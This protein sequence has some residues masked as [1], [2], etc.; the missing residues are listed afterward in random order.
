[1]DECLLLTIRGRP[2]NYANRISALFWI[3]KYPDQ[4]YQDSIAPENITVNIFLHSS[5]SR[6]LIKFIPISSLTML[7]CSALLH[8]APAHLMRHIIIL[9]ALKY[10]L[11]SL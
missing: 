6:S 1:M 10:G 5:L 4:E 8:P 9:T 2:T 3:M 11:I 7:Y